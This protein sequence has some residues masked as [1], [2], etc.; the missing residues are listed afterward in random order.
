MANL[1]VL[2]RQDC[3]VSTKEINNKNLESTYKFIQKTLEDVQGIGLMIKDHVFLRHFVSEFGL[4][5]DILYIESQRSFTI[6]YC[7]QT[8]YRQKQTFVAYGIKHL[9]DHCSDTLDSIKIKHALTLCPKNMFKTF[10]S[11]P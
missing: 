6:A 4:T 11:F 3:W 5:T 10:I 1:F 9:T 8:D 2:S 7:I